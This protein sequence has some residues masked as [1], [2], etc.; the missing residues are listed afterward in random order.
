[1]YDQI[2]GIGNYEGRKTA[3]MSETVER[4]YRTIGSLAAGHGSRME[5][6]LSDPSYKEAFYHHL[7]IVGD[8][9]KGRMK[10]R[11]PAL[12]QAIE[13]F[14]PHMARNAAPE[15]DY[16][17][18]YNLYAG[19][20][21]SSETAAGMIGSVAEAGTLEPK[22]IIAVRLD[23]YNDKKDKEH[24]H[25]VYTDDSYEC[26]TQKL[27]ADF[28]S[29]GIIVDEPTPFTAVATYTTVNQDGSLAPPVCVPLYLGISKNTIIDK[30][31]AYHPKRLHSG[32]PGQC[33][34][35]YNRTATPE[36][37]ADY[38]YSD[39]VVKKE[40]T[41]QWLSV[42]LPFA[43]S[44][45][46]NPKFRFD[47]FLE[48]ET[49]IMISIKGQEGACSYPDK[50]VFKKVFQIKDDVLCWSFKGERNII[51]PGWPF[52]KIKAA[53]DY[54]N[55]NNTLL[56]ERVSNNVLVSF[57]AKI[58]F[59]VCLKGKETAIPHQAVFSSDVYE[60]A[61]NTAKMDYVCLWWGCLS[62]KTKI[63]MADGTDRAISKISQGDQVKL[64]DGRS[65][66]VEAVLSGKEE[67]LIHIVTEKHELLASSMHPVL[68]GRGLVRAKDLNA[69]DLILTEDGQER[70][71][72]AYEEACPGAVYNLQLREPG[73]LIADGV[74]SG[75]FD[76]QQSALPY[77]QETGAW[78]PYTPRPVAD[79][80]AMLLAHRRPVQ[81]SAVENMA[82]KPYYACRFAAEEGSS[83]VLKLKGTGALADGAVCMEFWMYIQG[84][85]RELFSQ[86]SGF[87]LMADENAL[88]IA[89]EGGQ[90]FT[91]RFQVPLRGAWNQIFLASDGRE[92]HVGINGFETDCFALDGRLLDPDCDLVIGRHFTGY[93]RRIILYRTYLEASVLRLRMFQNI[94]SDD[95]EHLAAF[96]DGIGETLKDT[97]PYGLKVLCSAS[98]GRV[99]AAG[100]FVPAKGHGAGLPNGRVQLIGKERA[101]F[102][103]YIKCYILPY[104]KRRSVLWSSGDFNHPEAVWLYFE[105]ETGGEGE[106][107]IKYAGTVYAVGAQVVSGT[108]QD[109]IVS[110]DASSCRLS[111]YQNGSLAADFFS[112]KPLSEKHENSFCVGNGWDG[113]KD[114]PADAMFT[115][116]AVYHVPVGGQKA[117][118]MYEA[119]PFL[120]DPQLVA[121][122]G[123]ENGKGK[124][125]LSGQEIYAAGGEWTVCSNISAYPLSAEHYWYDIDVETGGYSPDARKVFRLFCIYMETVFG[126]AADSM[127][128]EYTQAVC[129][130][131][132]E[133]LLDRP[134]I[135]QALAGNAEDDVLC[136]VIGEFHE[137]MEEL[138]TLTYANHPYNRI[139]SRMAD[140]MGI[141]SI[142]A[143]VGAIVSAGEYAADFE[144]EA[145]EETF[146]KMR[147]VPFT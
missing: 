120:L 106:L 141:N 99:S 131:V 85:S 83:A 29:R 39:V 129:W 117:A 7:G 28:M 2:T 75:D 3:E 107:K 65:T 33:I 66:V 47:R 90:V 71:Q 103:V 57:Y 109:L 108:W 68:T 38:S 26:D 91:V 134:Y 147:H 60:T 97:G 11:Y 87:C 144:P 42:H 19:Q 110:Y 72:G 88:V 79:D 81:R 21:K 62:G 40:G 18:K 122:F 136:G 84:E 114:A 50:S 138:L 64:A 63:R 142:L 55:W 43:G 112:V 14:S 92:L 78:K 139:K 98:C 10:E 36:D 12:Y 143:S 111:V 121:L 31:E 58:A 73:N 56:A 89:V 51:Q 101:D 34:V 54:E 95:M 1:M 77:E 76:A 140:K 100:G 4:Q 125:Y 20:V 32:T 45:R 6:D 27:L 35:C 105:R 80:L 41:R 146:E 49:E 48:Q 16:Q 9:E 127:N 30:M 17:D 8:E 123:F 59:T 22:S 145:L 94:C 132:G 116:A 15:D 124:E 67:A 82:A 104:K 128:E 69:A 61:G 44:I 52:P 46:L 102:T 113:A 24:R 37:K 118:Q 74:V 115:T 93:I 133:N 119:Q 137:N 96:L 25:P 13:D 130:Y 23:I 135:A 126:I 70:L 5:L 86:E 53:Y